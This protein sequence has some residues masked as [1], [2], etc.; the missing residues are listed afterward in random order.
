MT[1]TSNI[2]V[3]NISKAYNQR[4]ILKAV[5]LYLNRGEVVGLF[6]PNGAGKT[7]CFDIIAGLVK[8]DSGQLL[9][10]DQDITKLPIYM[11]GR[12]GL[13][14]L[15]QEPS[16]FQG[17]SVA[18]NLKAV[19]E[20]SEPDRQVVKRR[21]QELLDEFL[22]SHLSNLSASTLSG[23]ERR[24]VEIARILALKPKFIM[25]DEPLAGID[26]L[27]VNDIKDLV[28]H[29]KTQNLGILVTDHNVRDTLDI[30]DRAYIM[31][32][33]SILIEGR[34]DQ[35]VSSDQVREVYLGHSFKLK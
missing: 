34:P 21:T 2:Q 14:Y 18:D 35:I 16:I 24:R 32:N 9:F 29:L 15:P 4:L 10:N 11:R 7:T 26:P 12:L 1:L 30:V 33:G 6:G 17:L 23:G 13:G 5:S 8:A 27:A 31:Y 19:L 3:K 22:I 20:I 28:G 25:L